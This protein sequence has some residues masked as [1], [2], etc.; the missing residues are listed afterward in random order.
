[1]VFL[2]FDS[3]LAGASFRRYQFGRQEEKNTTCKKRPPLIGSFLDKDDIRG[4]DVKNLFCVQKKLSGTSKRFIITVYPS[5]LN[6]F[7]LPTLWSTMLWSG[8]SRRKRYETEK[9]I[10]LGSET[11]F[12]SKWPNPDREWL[13]EWPLVAVNTLTAFHPIF[14]SGPY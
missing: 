10:P 13:V 9:N 7:S 8:I 11:I 6:F 1:M 14:R 3:L 4:R 5:C 2:V 12:L